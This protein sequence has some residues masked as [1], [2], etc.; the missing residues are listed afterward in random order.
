MMPT[1]NAR[2]GTHQAMT[3]RIP[4]PR[5]QIPDSNP[6]TKR[7]IVDHVPSRVL[8]RADAIEEEEEA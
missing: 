8:F 5:L 4:A 7:G 6:S 2:S 3:Q 1:R